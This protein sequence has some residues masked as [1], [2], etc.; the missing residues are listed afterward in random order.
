MNQFGGIFVG[1]FFHFLKAAAVRYIM[2]FM[3]NISQKKIFFR[4]FDLHSI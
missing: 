2:K 3:E 4:E 1:Y